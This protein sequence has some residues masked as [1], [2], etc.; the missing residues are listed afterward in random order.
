MGTGDAMGRAWHLGPHNL[1]GVDLLGL[2]VDGQPERHL[3][4]HLELQLFGH[5][6]DM[7]VHLLL[8]PLGIVPARSC[9]DVQQW[10]A[11]KETST[12]RLPLHAT[13]LYEPAPLLRWWVGQRWQL[14]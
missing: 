12:K 8:Q 4:P 2:L 5:G 1:L 3:V 13:N 14:Q 6:V 9:Q 11:C 7:E 10:Q